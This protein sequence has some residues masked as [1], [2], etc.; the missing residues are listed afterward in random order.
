MTTG[1]ARALGDDGR[2]TYLDQALWKRLGGAPGEEPDLEAWLALQCGMVP[3]AAAGVL[4]LGAPDVGP[5][6]PV[7]AWPAGRALGPV[8]SAAAEAAAVRRRPVVQGAEESGAAGARSAGLAWPVLADGKLHGVVAVEVVGLGDTEVR[9]AMRQLQWGAAWVELL[10][11][12]RA[13]RDEAGRQERVATALDLIASAIEE[14]RFKAAALGVATE[15]A[16]RLGAERVSIGFLDGANIEI[17]ALSHTATFNQR[18]ELVQQIAAAM[19][20]ALD[21]RASIVHPASEDA[22]LVTREHGKLAQQS[23]AG[24]V[25]TA[26]LFVRDSWFGGLTVELPAG[27][28]PDDGLV[29]LLET[30]GAV[31]GPVLLEKRLNDRPVIF[32]LAE[33]LGQ[34]GRR[35]L[36]AEYYGRKLAAVIV[37]ALAAF[38]SFASKEYR[39]AADAVL[40]GGVQR[41]ISVPVDGFVVSAD[42]RAGDIIR[43]GQEMARLDERELLLE[44]QRWAAELSQRAL[45]YDQAQARGQRAEAQIIRAQMAQAEAQIELLDAQLARMVLVAPF[46]AVVISGDLSQ[47][48]GKAVRR[49]EPL[50]E[51][52]PLD[53]YRVVLKVD[54]IDIDELAAGQPG[55]LVISSMPDRRFGLVVDNVTPVAVAEEGRN[56]FRVE[57]SLTESDERLRPGMSGIGK[58]EAGERKLIW[59]WTHGLTDWVRLKLWAWWR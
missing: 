43:A 38:F 50:F 52:A 14:P 15:L 16:L 2:L 40:E 20:E 19:D 11:A 28:A 56:Y 53:S 57:A 23:G 37:L 32:K 31:V 39:V 18:M 44:R 4:V 58:V 51:V 36:G 17:A 29:E 48:I 24:A 21:Q 33:S 59:I 1:D 10:L 9:A 49:G 34:Q 12:R 46:D 54:E 7:A 3:G 47:S 22:Q 30:I 35:L 26:P 25:V 42:V 55:H 6:R 27:R 8:L 5:F 13:S 41:A 45:E